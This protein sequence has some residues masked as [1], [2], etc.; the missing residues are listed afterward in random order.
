MPSNARTFIW[1]MVLA[2]GMA[3]I[4]YQLHAPGDQSTSTDAGGQA[5]HGAVAPKMLIP[6]SLK[7]A[8]AIDIIVRGNAHRFQ[9]DGENRWYLPKHV[10]AAPKPEGAKTGAAQVD[11]AKRAYRADPARASRISKA[12]EMFGRARVERVVA[13]G[14]FDRDKYGLV[15]PEIIVNIFTENRA[16]PALTLLV[17]DLAP[18][19]LSRYVRVVERQTLVTIPNYHITNLFQLLAK[20]HS[21]IQAGTE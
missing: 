15:L 17:G 12:F 2:L 8:S 5:E 20:A 16:A 14:T 7:K 4:G 3:A 19:L 11:V 10:H 9:R 18:D 6:F 21:E 1:I 13:R